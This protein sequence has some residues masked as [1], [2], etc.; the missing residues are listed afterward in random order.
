MRVAEVLA[1]LERTTGHRPR[2][3]GANWLVRCPA[4]EDREP[5]LNVGEGVDDRVLLNCFAGCAVEAVLAACGLDASDLFADNGRAPDGGRRTARPGTRNRATDREPA[6]LPGE[7]ELEAWRAALV[8]SD[9]ALSRLQTLRGWTREAVEGLELGL[10]D[11][12]VVIPVRDATGALVNVLHY[13]PNPQRRAGSKLLSQRGRPRELFPVPERVADRGAYLWLLE[14][15][16][17]AVTA[18]SLG[19]PAV[20]I[21]GV[22]GWRDAWSVRFRG[23]RVAVC[24]DSDRAGREAAQRI[25][26]AVAREAAEV[27]LVDLD[28]TGEEGRD[29]TDWALPA[30]TDELRA[31]ARRLLEEIA[32]AS[33][34]VASTPVGDAP[35][36]AQRRTVPASRRA[37]ATPYAQIR[38]EHVE[39]LEPGRIP[40]GAVSILAGEPGL[41]KSLYSVRLAA[42]LSRRDAATLL[43]SAEDS[44][45]AT[46]RPRLDACEAVSRLVHAVRL[47]GEAGAAGEGLTLPRDAEELDHLI[48]ETGARLVV[49]DP[50]VAHLDAGVDSH[51]DASVRQA[52]APLAR[53]AASRNCA[54]LG[55][56][57]VNKA[58]GSD[59]YRRLSGS[60]GFGG[61]ARSVLLFGRDPDDG[62]PEHG[63]G[64]LLAHAKCNVAALAPSQ[65]WRVAPILL[66]PAG[67]EPESETARLELVGESEH[68]YRSLLDG[69]SDAD[70]R[71]PRDEAED[72][73]REELANGPRPAKDMQRAARDAGIALRTLDR[74]KRR[75]RVSP[76][77][78]GFG[79]GA[80]W[81]WELPNP[82]N[83]TDEERQPADDDW[84][85]SH[86]APIHAES[87]H[88]TGRE[89]RVG[90]HASPVAIFGDET[91]PELEGEAR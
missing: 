65:C 79:S 4:H 43:L 48:A 18:T 47:A 33:P 9:Q 3:S 52:L 67:D 75:L 14:G 72:F 10:C 88:S 1:V 21:P 2:R 11:G 17:D 6:R 44:E 7:P 76:R 73:L 53:I 77:R 32:E 20:S 66:P 46:I 78:Q 87:E 16:P 19:L 86:E 63:P 29:L 28:P 71:L 69:E 35:D 90:R 50:V 59:W 15:E 83:A 51:R 41:G 55:V 26:R 25:A 91:P 42:E 27:R 34:I 84:R 12:R 68:G 64:R 36:E 40:L 13:A 62:D 23:R 30:T 45:G 58:I 81:T 54:V 74:A 82:K 22:K 39:W 49:V 89:A 5:S 56:L 31:E 85:T 24:F 38:R 60:G 80:H 37:V 57:H 61:A 8:G 70:D